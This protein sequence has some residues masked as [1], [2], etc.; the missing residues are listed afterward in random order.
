MYFSSFQVVPDMAAMQDGR[1][2]ET[3]VWVFLRKE[4]G[5]N[6]PLI[7]Q[8]QKSKAWPLAEVSEE[9]K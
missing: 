5:R 6:L 3:E 2:G 4:K 7:S 1:T 8:P 9:V